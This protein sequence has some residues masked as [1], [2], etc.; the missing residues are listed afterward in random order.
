MHNY[1]SKFL[2]AWR[3]IKRR[4]WNL[5]YTTHNNIVYNF[6]SD[7]RLQLDKRI[8]TFIYNAR[9]SFAAVQ[10]TLFRLYICLQLLS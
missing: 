6:S 5:P 2:T 8:V 10:I 9:N 1:V 4:I 3:K 7:I